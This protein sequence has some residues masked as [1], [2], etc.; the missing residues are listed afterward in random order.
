MVS[1]TARIERANGRSLDQVEVS[2]T[3]AEPTVG[4]QA[5]RGE[6]VSRSADGFQP[7]ERLWLTLSNGQKGTASV[8]RT[9]FDSRTPEKTVIEFTGSGALG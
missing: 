1:Y 9:L 6:F 2:V 8:S 3:V 4:R 7:S 5:W